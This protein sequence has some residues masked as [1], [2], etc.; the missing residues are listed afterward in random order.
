[1]DEKFCLECGDSIVGRTD[2]K[3]CSDQCRNSYNNKLNSDSVNTIRNINNHLRKNR[4]ILLSFNPEGKTKIPREKLIKAGFDFKYHTH[5]HITQ[6]GNIYIYCYDQGY[7]MLE[8][9]FV[10]LIADKKGE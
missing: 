2:K 6:K 1:M 3:F 5:Q 8:D 9:N 4:R 7:L 10:L